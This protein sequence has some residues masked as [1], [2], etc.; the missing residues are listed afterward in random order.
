MTVFSVLRG[1]PLHGFKMEMPTS[2]PDW[3]PVLDGSVGAAPKLH[4]YK[5]TEETI[6]DLT[7]W[8]FIK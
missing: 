7:V 5:M 2:N 8:E 1:G 3:Q 4:Y 6:D